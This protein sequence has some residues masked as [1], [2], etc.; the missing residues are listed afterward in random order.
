MEDKPDDINTLIRDAAHSARPQVPT[1]PA[2]AA[3][4]AVGTPPEQQQASDAM[5]ALIRG[6]SRRRAQHQSV[7]EEL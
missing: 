4:E 2:V 3:T 6:A 5:N 1:R 7:Q